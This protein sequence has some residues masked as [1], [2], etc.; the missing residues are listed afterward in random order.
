MEM[1]KYKIR[2]ISH[3]EDNTQRSVSPFVKYYIAIGTVVGLVGGIIYGVFL[4]I[5]NMFPF[6][7]YLV[8]SS[9]ATVGI[10][11]HFA[12][13]IV[14]GVVFLLV[15]AK[16]I[17]NRYSRGVMFGLCYGGLW[18]LLGSLIIIP[19]LLVVGAQSSIELLS[20]WILPSLVWHLIFGL[21]L[22]TAYVY[23]E[24]YMYAWRLNELLGEV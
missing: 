6:V 11:V 12:I 15:F 21:A 22:G 16:H 20:L 1:T 13:S 10:V 8:G 17:K 24:L 23:V 18:W 4:S 2:T 14:L 7:A 5:K 9:E 19:I 3:I